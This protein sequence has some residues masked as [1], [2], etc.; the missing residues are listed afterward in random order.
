MF[1]DRCVARKE[2]DLQTGRAVVFPAPFTLWQGLTW[3]RREGALVASGSIPAASILALAL[4]SLGGLGC[5]SIPQGTAAVDAVSVEGT[6]A[7][8]SSDVEQKL[9]TAP[10]PK[11]IGLFRG[12]LYD[13]EIFD[14]SVLQRDL[15]RV[16]RYY[17][18]RGY[19]E[20]QARAGRIRYKSEKHV[21]VTIEV[22][23][24]DPVLVREARIDGLDGLAPKDAKA[25]TAALKKLVKSGATFEEEPYVKAESAMR[26]VLTDRGYAW[27]TIARRADV[28]LPAH[29]ADL[30][31]T[32]RVG[33][34]ATFGAVTIE[35]LGELPQPPVERAL[36]IEKGEGYSTESLDTAQQAVLNLGTFSSVEI[37]PELPEPPPASGIVPLR[38]RVQVQKLKSVILGGGVELDA[39]RTQAHLHVGWEHKNL[40]GGF[41][42]FTVDLRPGLD[43]FPT[44]LPSFEAPT[45][46]LFEERFRAELRQ[47]GFLEART[48]GVMS[49]EIN[50]Y[51]LLLT[52]KVDA[53]APV[54]GY[55]E[56]KGSLGL[57]RSLWK[58]FGAPSYNFQWNKP[59][60]YRGDLDPDVG[61]IIVSYIDLLGNLDLRD[62]RIRPHKGIYVQHDLQFAG[63][64]GSA[65]DVR[66]QPEV[67]GYVPL[68]KKVTLAARATVGFLFPF[69]YGDAPK[70]G[71]DDPGGSKRAAW[72]RDIEIIY[73]RGFFSGGP[74]SNRGYPLRGIGPHDAVPF[75]SPGLTSPALEA[76]CAGNA[77]VKPASCAVPLGGL[78]IWEASL[79]LRFPIL[80]PLSGSLFCDTSDV[81]PDQLSI[82][83]DHPHLSC[84]PGLR[85]DTPIGPVRLDI[86]YRL[87][88]AAQ[89]PTGAD[90]RTEGTPGT[91]FGVPLALAFG[92]GE[93]F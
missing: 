91:I 35:G 93:A 61:P 90:L 25:V 4:G 72:I 16:E 63:L 17:H 53:T 51:P 20:A 3:P 65:R 12:I 36:D 62:D 58:L 32:A 41:R 66:I 11:L 88:G 80:G 29:R 73:L 44:R 84:G 89:Y 87:P 81:S 78:S 30:R 60:T 34:R 49:H 39:I 71:S 69:N 14:R 38:V 43:L 6:V 67:R 33:P 24:G 45:A 37:T 54:L 13:Y 75:Y 19:Y 22:K 46:V 55:V 40:F 52:T 86:G 5:A 1:P 85:Y 47:P 48:N 9:A 21:E 77:A 57:D 79:E 10:S 92:I 31:Y 76:A 83:L 23:E 27:A 42:H 26:R 59:F 68:G 15:E 74:S 82:R 7:L 8:S 64:G 50:T 18:A 28:D 2:R 56:Y 70:S